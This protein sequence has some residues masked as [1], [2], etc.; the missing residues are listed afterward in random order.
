[1]EDTA[2]S[3]EMDVEIERVKIGEVELLKV[4]N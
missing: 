4:V 2:E 1:M 3:D